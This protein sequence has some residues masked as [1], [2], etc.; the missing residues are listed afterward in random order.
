MTPLSEK[1][2]KGSNGSMMSCYENDDK[3]ARM[4]TV[5]NVMIWIASYS[6]G[7]LIMNCLINR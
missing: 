6:G 5:G 7:S 3:L 4:K 2:G 1:C